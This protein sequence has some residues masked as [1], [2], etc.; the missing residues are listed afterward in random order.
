MA[1]SSSASQLAYHTKFWKFQETDN[2]YLHFGRPFERSGPPVGLYDP[3]FDA[4]KE[5]LKSNDEI[6]LKMKEHVFE[7][8]LKSSSFFRVEDSHQEDM[9]NLL[10]LLLG[11]I[12]LSVKYKK[13]ISDGT[14]ITPSPNND[15]SIPILICKMKNEIGTGKSNP[16]VQAAINYMHTISNG[17]CMHLRDLLPTATNV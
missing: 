13:A 4:F 16:S 17:F 12:P 14:I 7:Y 8:T 3:I 1:K 15:S 5:G 9:K 6:P 11:D 2:K 10:H